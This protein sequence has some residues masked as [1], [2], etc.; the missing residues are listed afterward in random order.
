[1]YIYKVILERLAI[2]LMLKASVL[3]VHPTLIV[4]EAG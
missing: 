4:Y 1:M 3:F 2:I